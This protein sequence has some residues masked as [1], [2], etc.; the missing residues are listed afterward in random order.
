MKLNFSD[1]GQTG[2]NF[3]LYMA[4]QAPSTYEKVA[5]LSPTTSDPTDLN[6]SF[7][8]DETSTKI[9]IKHL[10]GDTYS[11]TKNGRERKATLLVENFLKMNS[12][13]IRVLRDDQNKVVGLSLDQDRIR[14]VQFRRQ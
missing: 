6:A 9:V 4:S 12:Y 11:L 1:I 8:N 13:L 5:D 14:N 10:E 7:V 3:T 2:Q